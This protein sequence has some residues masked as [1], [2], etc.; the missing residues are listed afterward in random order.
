MA[1]AA[2]RVYAFAFLCKSCPELND[3][4]LNRVPESPYLRNNAFNRINSLTIE[5]S[6]FGGL[7]LKRY[8][9]HGSSGFHSRRVRPCSSVAIRMAP[10]A[11]TRIDRLAQRAVLPFP[12]P[13]PDAPCFDLLH[14]TRPRPGSVLIAPTA[15]WRREGIMATPSSSTMASSSH[16]MPMSPRFPALVPD[17]SQRTHQPRRQ[18]AAAIASRLSWVMT[19][20]RRLQRRQDDVHARH[21]DSPGYSRVIGR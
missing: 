11:S 8:P 16:V 14:A 1:V 3:W 17:R 21:P 20:A 7:S 2:H 18:D 5:K 9:E 10:V 4:I 19:R 13:R 12:G 6:A 15:R